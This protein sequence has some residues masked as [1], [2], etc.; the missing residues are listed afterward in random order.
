MQGTDTRIWTLDENYADNIM[1]KVPGTHKDQKEVVMRKVIEDFT[2]RIEEDRVERTTEMSI[3]PNGAEQPEQSQELPIDLWE[4][5]NKFEPEPVTF[6]TPPVRPELYA[7]PQPATQAYNR[8]DQPMTGQ[9]PLQRNSG[10]SD[11]LFI[12]A[13]MGLP[14]P[15]DSLVGGPTY[16]FAMPTQ[17]QFASS[18]QID[19]SL[20][21]N[22]PSAHSASLPENQPS[23]SPPSSMPVYP[24]AH[25]QSIQPPHIPLPCSRCGRP[26]RG[27]CMFN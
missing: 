27:S 3:D 15:S 7:P 8:Y 2:I 11:G 6:A 24:A 18:S 23:A 10:P 21:P 5:A 19:P 12:P 9:F 14:Y 26:H 22:F 13:P 17:P 4:F 1:E 25:Y 16:S 20:L